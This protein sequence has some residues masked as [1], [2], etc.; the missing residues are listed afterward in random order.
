MGAPGH[1][2]MHGGV[3]GQGW[4]SQ[5][6]TNKD[7]KLSKDEAIAW[8]D[9][10]D[11]NKDGFLS[12]DELAAARAQ[13]AG[14]RMDADGNGLVSREEAKNFPMLAQNFDAIDANKDGQ[15]SRDEMRAYHEAHRGEGWARLDTNKDGMVSREEAKAAPRLS[16]NFDA[17]DANKDGQLSQDEL[18][19]AWAGRNHR[20][21]ARMDTNGDGLISR[22]EAKNAPMLSQNFDAIDSNKDGFLSREEIDAWRRAQ[23]PTANAPVKP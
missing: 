7:G 5:F 16:A 21:G 11:T 2:P 20:H 15:L 18:R 19:S 10:L 14:R 12:Q 8:F 4:M 22:D 13:F 17:L 3:R 1:G 23:Q 6:D 9:R